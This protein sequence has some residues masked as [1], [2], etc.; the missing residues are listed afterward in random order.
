MRIIHRTLTAKT[1]AGPSNADIKATRRR[2]PVVISAAGL[3]LCNRTMRY[4][5]LTDTTDFST[6]KDGLGLPN[7]TKKVPLFP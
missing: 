4:L 1:G 5:G 3:I 2:H 7:N 6:V